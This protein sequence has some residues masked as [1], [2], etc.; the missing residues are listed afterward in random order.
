MKGNMLQHPQVLEALALRKQYREKVDAIVH[1]AVQAYRDHKRSGRDI[2]MQAVQMWCRLCVKDEVI[3]QEILFAVE[4]VS[5]Q[6]AM[7]NTR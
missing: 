3:A 7:V 6:Y 1:A 2:D 5:E 4:E